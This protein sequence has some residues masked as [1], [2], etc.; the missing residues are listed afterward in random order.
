MK[1]HVPFNAMRSMPN[2]RFFKRSMCL[3]DV[4]GRQHEV[5]ERERELGGEGAGPLASRY[6]ATDAPCPPPHPFRSPTSASSRAASAT[7][8]CPPGGVP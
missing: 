3:L 2:S 1:G 7:P 5:R 8:A 6:A 4:Y